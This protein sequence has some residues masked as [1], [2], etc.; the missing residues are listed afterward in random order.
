MDG[1]LGLVEERNRSWIKVVV[2][3]RVTEHVDELLRDMFR[4][5]LGGEERR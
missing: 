5:R 2:I 4:L 1:G 3:S